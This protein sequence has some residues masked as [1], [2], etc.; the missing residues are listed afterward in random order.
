MYFFRHGPVA[1]QRG[2]LEIQLVLE[3]THLVLEAQSIRITARQPVDHVFELGDLELLVLD[4]R[5]IDEDAEE[6]E[7]RHGECAAHPDAVH[8]L[9]P[10]TRRVFR[11]NKT[12]R[13]LVARGAFGRQFRNLCGGQRRNHFHALLDAFLQKWLPDDG[14]FGIGHEETAWRRSNPAFQFTG[15]GHL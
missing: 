6:I 9:L 4:E 14:E 12:R 7:N 15:P 8:E 11:R 1:V 10:V 5:E 13:R 2:K 3:H